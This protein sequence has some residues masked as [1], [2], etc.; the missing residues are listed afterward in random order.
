M[1]PG[2]NPTHF[3]TPPRRS[4]DRHPTPAGRDTVSHLNLSGSHRSALVDQPVMVGGGVIA[5]PE[6]AR[7]ERIGFGRKGSVALVTMIFIPVHGGLDG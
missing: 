4:P 5:R 1:T 3:A 7:I 6:L 2:S